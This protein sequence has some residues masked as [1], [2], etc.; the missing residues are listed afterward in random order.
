MVLKK[1]SRYSDLI[2]FAH[3]CSSWGK[4]EDTKGVIWWRLHLYT[5]VDQCKRK[6]KIQSR[7]DNPDAHAILDTSHWMNPNEE[8]KACIKS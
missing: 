3:G 4:F 7:V 8:A 1:D 2:C 5:Y 6:L